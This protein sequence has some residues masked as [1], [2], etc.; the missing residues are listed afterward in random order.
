M[1]FTNDK[2]QS[3]PEITYET[4]TG[5]APKEQPSRDEIFEM[6]S[7]E[8]RRCVIYYLQQ[9]R[10]PVAM[11]SIVEY[12]AAWQ[13]DKPVRAVTSR[14][15]TCVYSAL[16]QTHLPKL[17]S[18]GLIE[19]D[20]DRSEIS[21][22]DS[23]EHARLYLEYDPGNDIEWSSLYLGLSALG[24]VFATAHTAGFAPFGTISP[25][26]LVWGLILLFGLSAVAHTIHN[27]RNK[28]SLDGVF[29]VEE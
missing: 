18:V 25:E 26:V 24:A 11:R 23:A 29:E 14:E 2:I 28:Q 22:R 13:N 1:R 12:V 4:P 15:R 9:Q 17:D 16:H 10:G 7:N 3:I 21:I 5:E 20:R 27:R 19:Y 6:L 8:R